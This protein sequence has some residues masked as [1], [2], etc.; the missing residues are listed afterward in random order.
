V[1]PTLDP[2]TD[3]QARRKIASRN[4]R[5]AHA[6]ARALAHA[7]V[8]PDIIS[9]ASIGFGV[10][11]A[12]GFLLTRLD[13]PAFVLGGLVLAVIGMMMRLVCNLLDGMVA[14]EYGKKTRH[15]ELMNDIPDRISDCLFF[16]AAGYA[17]PE[18]WG[19]TL[20]LAVALLAVMTA[21]VRT[22]GK[23]IGADWHFAGPMAKQHRM[24]VMSLACLAAGAGW[25]ADLHR[26]AL[27]AGLLIVA[28]GCLLTLINRLRRIV[29][30]LYAS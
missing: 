3:P 13:T 11:G 7:G 9:I 16:I 26:E 27:G 4:T 5:L 14:V 17:A 20:G 12:G 30:D 8:S 22:L 23:A 24:A 10:I 29:R 19:P 2:R 25:F 21:Y 18:P 1:T 28:L 15:G 6:S